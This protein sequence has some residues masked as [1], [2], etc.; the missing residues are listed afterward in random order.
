[1][2]PSVN[3]PLPLH[4]Q[5]LYHANLNRKEV[6]L[7]F[8]YGYHVQTRLISHIQVVG[9]VDE[10][11]PMVCEELGIQLTKEEKR[12]NIRPLLSLVLSRFLGEMSGTRAIFFLLACLLID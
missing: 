8:N 11:L 10:C 2:Q 12:M 5:L 7:F 6:S 9:D 1:M 3:L 4:S